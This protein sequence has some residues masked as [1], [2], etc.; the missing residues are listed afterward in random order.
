[1]EFRK[2]MFSSAVWIMFIIAV[3]G[4]VVLAGHDRA[5]AS[6]SGPAGAWGVAVKAPVSVG[7]QACASPGYC[8]TAAGGPSVLVARNGTGVWG[9]AIPVN[10]APLGLGAPGPGAE[11][12]GA[13]ISQV[14]CPSA[15]N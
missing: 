14:A 4:L 6:A 13:S 2:R 11:A 12:G 9:K 10:T 3:L 8:V 15:G 1:M 7:R 5:Q